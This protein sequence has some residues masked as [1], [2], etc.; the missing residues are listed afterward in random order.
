MSVMHMKQNQENH[1]AERDSSDRTVNVQL[2][3]QPLC[4]KEGETIASAM[5]EAGMGKSIQIGC[6]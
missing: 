4:V 1:M 3:G 6:G 5:W 2:A